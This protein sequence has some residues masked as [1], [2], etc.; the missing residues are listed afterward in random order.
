MNPYRLATWDGAKW[1]DPDPDEPIIGILRIKTVKGTWI[2]L[3]LTEKDA[4]AFSFTKTPE[5]ES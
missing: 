5:V 2:R 1:I 3:D 4:E